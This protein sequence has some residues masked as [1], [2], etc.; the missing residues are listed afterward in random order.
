MAVSSYFL[1]KNATCLSVWL[2][3]CLNVSDCNLSKLYI[4]WKMTNPIAL[5]VDNGNKTNSTNKMI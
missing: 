3:T 5:A 2:R 4:L 1:I